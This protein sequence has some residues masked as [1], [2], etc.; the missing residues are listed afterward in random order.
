MRHIQTAISRRAEPEWFASWFDSVHYHTL[1]AHRSDEEAAA[2]VHQLI[3]RLRPV[4]GATVLDLGCGT[5]RHA[6][7]LASSGLRVIG[8]DLSTESI[9]RAKEFEARNLWFRR[10]D[11][12]LPFGR[13]TLDYVV[14][15]FTSFGYFDDP[16]DEVAVIH[17][18]ARALKPGGTLVLDYLNVRYAERH[19]TREEVLTRR[20]TTYRISRWTNADHMFKRIVVEAGGTAPREYTERVAKLTVE[21]FE[22]MFSLCDM[23]LEATYGDYRL[24]P[25][26]LETSPRLILVA[27]KS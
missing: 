6:R 20:E 10:Q 11:M 8:V 15:L 5:G 13:E 1:Y 27:R 23:K 18:I 7:Q 22:F 2:F 26:D 21:D 14:N 16:S 25:F 19:L 17:N 9:R 4:A 24:E 3:A 12:R